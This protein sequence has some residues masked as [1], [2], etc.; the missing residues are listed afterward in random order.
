MTGG[1]RI[2]SM[3]SVSYCVDEIGTSDGEERE[4]TIRLDSNHDGVD[5]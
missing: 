5:V 3:G 2:T 1:D 4:S